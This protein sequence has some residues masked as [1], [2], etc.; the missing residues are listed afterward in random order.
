[1]KVVI[2]GASGFIGKP[3]AESLSALGHN[4]IAISRNIPKNDN[5]S[6][7]TWL[8]ADLSIPL[9]YKDSIN[10]FSPDVVIHLAWQ[11]IPDFSLEKSKLN[12][13]QSIDFIS[14]ITS[15]KSCKKLLMPGSCWEYST[16]MGECNEANQSLPTNNFTW[17][18]HSLRLWVELACKNASI[19]LAWF[20]IFYVYGPNQRSESL[21]PSILTS[22]KNGHLPKISAPQNCNDFIYIEDVLEAFI[23]AVNNEF[24]SG[25]YNLG[26]G[27]S[28]SVLDV[29]RYS[30]KI[31]L[32]SSELSKRLADE[33]HVN[34]VEVNFWASILDT[35]N[36][37]D[38]SPKTNLFDGILK[39]WKSFNNK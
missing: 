27:S 13:T 19:S 15:I 12:L 38:W 6:S 9:T 34:S 29:C 2:T 14:F 23:K 30:E 24:E 21:I 22:L 11:D 33:I 10:A 1:M 17:A 35:K 3:L 16:S 18:K 8:K 7:V 20:R 5:G 37:F 36:A 39:T 4:V 32:N 25:I 31:V 28:S 26:S